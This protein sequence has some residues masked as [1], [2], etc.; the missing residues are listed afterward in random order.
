V[1]LA[2][3]I[4]RTDRVG[5]SRRRREHLQA[6]RTPGGD[7]HATVTALMKSCDKRRTAAEKHGNE[8]RVAGHRITSEMTQLSALTRS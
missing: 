5:A 1:K 3:A 8:P 6:L 4:G 7:V 2:D